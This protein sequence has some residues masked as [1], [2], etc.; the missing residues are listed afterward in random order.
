MKLLIQ[1]G[2]DISVGTFETHETPIHYCSKSGNVNILNEIIRFVFFL[3][4][5]NFFL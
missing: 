2:G 1:N 5:I 3:I 4:E